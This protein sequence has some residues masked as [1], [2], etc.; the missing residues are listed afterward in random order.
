MLVLAVHMGNPK[1]LDGNVIELGSRETHLLGN[2]TNDY[3]RI[4]GQ[5]LP[6]IITWAYGNIS[7]FNSSI[8]GGLPTPPVTLACIKANKALEGSQ[9]PSRA[10]DLRTFSWCILISLSTVLYLG[11]A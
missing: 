1:F 9:L 7:N 6:L 5:S 11:L 8:S 3:K 10:S 2:N 4:G